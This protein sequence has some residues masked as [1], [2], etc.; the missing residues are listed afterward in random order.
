MVQYVL[1]NDVEKTKFEKQYQ[2]PYGCWNTAIYKEIKP[3]ILM[4]ENMPSLKRVCYNIEMWENGVFAEVVVK[5]NE[6]E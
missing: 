4:L 6:L 1:V 5:G 3:A 2:L